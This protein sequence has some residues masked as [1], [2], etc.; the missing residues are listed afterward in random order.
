M[1]RQNA[2]KR[3]EQSTIVCHSHHTLDYTSANYVDSDYIPVIVEAGVHHTFR[4]VDRSS[5]LAWKYLAPGSSHYSGSTKQS[6]AAP[7]RRASSIVVVGCAQRP[8][9]DFDQHT[10]V[11]LEI[12]LAAIPSGHRGN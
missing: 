5:I 10:T 9:I 8:D 4:Q 1:T 2:R 12:N 7:R 11:Y 6:A 3:H